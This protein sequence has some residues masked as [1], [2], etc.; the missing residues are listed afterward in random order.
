MTTFVELLSL[1]DVDIR[2]AGGENLWLS[3]DAIQQEYVIRGK[4]GKS[5][6]VS[7]LATAKTEEEASK[8][9]L[10]EYIKQAG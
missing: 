6:R 8:K 9:F 10:A 2:L 4:K 3:W 1:Q 5:K 7:V